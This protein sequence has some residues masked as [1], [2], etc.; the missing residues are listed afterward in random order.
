MVWLDS[1]RVGTRTRGWRPAVPWRQAGAQPCPAREPTPFTFGS[2]IGLAP[3]PTS[4]TYIYMMCSRRPQ[5]SGSVPG[6]RPRW[7]FTGRAPMTYP[8]SRTWRSRSRPDQGRFGPGRACNRGG[9][10]YTHRLPPPAVS[11]THLHAHPVPVRT[12]PPRRPSPSLPPPPPAAARRRP[13]ER[14]GAGAP[15]LLQVNDPTSQLHFPL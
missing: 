10:S 4:P 11:T 8:V 14:R 1:R 2:S 9:L 12:L 15:L 5:R 7:G 6:P 3:A 13:T